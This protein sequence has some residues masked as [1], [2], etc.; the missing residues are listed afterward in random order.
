[1]ARKLDLFNLTQQ[2]FVAR[3]KEW[4]SAFFQ[5]LYEGRLSIEDGTTQVGPDGWPYLFAQTIVG[6]KEP[7]RKIIDWLS[8]KGIGLV[9][10]AHKQAPDYV[11]TYGMVWNCKERGEFISE[12][13][14]IK[15]G[16]VVF[17]KGKHV[18]AGPPSQEYLPGYVRK[19]LKQFFADQGIK[20]MKTV[21]VSTDSKHYDLI[22]S[23]ESLGEPP[24]SEHRGIAEA[25][26]WFLPSHYSIVIASEK[27]LPPFTHL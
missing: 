7:V 18:V 12:A 17:E 6:A 26:A 19:V 15:S 24:Q 4:E 16:K 8:E 5:A 11:F 22:F 13:P 9:V 23:L 25:I 27:G 3:D 21:V 14:E 20:D 2:P 1:L 10:N